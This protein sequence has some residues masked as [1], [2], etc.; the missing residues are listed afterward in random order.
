MENKI[1]KPF[2]LSTLFLTPLGFY[3]LAAS[4]EKIIQQENVSFE[5]CL[6]IIDSSKDKLSVVPEINDGAKQKRIAVFK[7]I[8]GS[9][10]IICDKSAGKITV[11][12]KIN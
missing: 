1:L 9:L 4:E 8:D 3:A 7:L 6:K 10:T 5:K 2:F 12:T 11:S